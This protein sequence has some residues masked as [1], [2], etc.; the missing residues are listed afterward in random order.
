MMG[1]TW[2]RQSLPT[3]WSNA[4]WRSKTTHDGQDQGE[5]EHTYDGAEE[6][7]AE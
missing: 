6:G 5:L 2:V 4:W 7:E 1:R 3:A